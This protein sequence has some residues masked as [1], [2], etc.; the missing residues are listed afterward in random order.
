MQ[1]KLENYRNN[2]L[3]YYLEGNKLEYASVSEVPDEYFD[4]ACTISEAI[5]YVQQLGCQRRSQH[6]IH[7]E[8][9]RCVLAVL[10]MAV[11]RYGEYFD[12]VY[13]GCS[14]NLPLNQHLILFGTTD[15]AVAENYG[16]VKEFT[17]VKGL[18][19]ISHR[20]SVVTNNY[21]YDDVEIIFFP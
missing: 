13:R 20:K 8:Y 19:F 18:R 1:T 15:R 4:N 7:S 14:G 17:K 10:R 3:N 12:V 9:H 11:E 2:F 16:E 5:S 21:D 6:I